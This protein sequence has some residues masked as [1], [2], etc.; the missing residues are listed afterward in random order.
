MITPVPT[1]MAINGGGPTSAA[2]IA[3]LNELYGVVRPLG[4]NGPTT[5]RPTS[6][7]YVGLQY[8]DTTLGKPVFLKTVSPAAWVDATG[9]S[10]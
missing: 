8:F 3:W 1:T 7:L 5:Q 4:G 2:W 6:G 10:V 9:A